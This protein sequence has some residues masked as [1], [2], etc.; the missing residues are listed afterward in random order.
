M[1]GANGQTRDNAAHM[2][3]LTQLRVGSLVG[4][5]LGIDPV[6]G[7]LLS[8][9]GGIPGAGNDQVGRFAVSAAGGREVVT[10]HGT[11]HDAAGYLSNYHGMGPGYNYVPNVRGFLSDANP[12]AGQSN[13]VNFYYNLRRF[14]DPYYRPPSPGEGT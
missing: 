11:A 9:T 5:A 8:P 12:L 13:G 7:A 14:G 6:F 1:D 2:G 10:D 3:S 4:E